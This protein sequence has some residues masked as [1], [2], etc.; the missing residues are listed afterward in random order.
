MSLLSVFEGDF[1]KVT[2][3]ILVGTSDVPVDDTE[4]TNK[5][6]VDDE[7]NSIEHWLRDVGTATVFL[8]IPG[9][10]VAGSL[11]PGGALEIESTLNVVKGDITLT[12]PQ[13]NISNDLKVDSILEKTP[14]NG[15][16]IDSLKI[17]DNTLSSTLNLELQTQTNGVINFSDTGSTFAVL[18]AVGLSFQVPSVLG[19]TDPNGT[20]SLFSTSDVTKGAITMTASSV[21]IS[22]DLKVNSILEKTN[23]NGINI[24][25]SLIK[26][27]QL[28]P[29]S[30]TISNFIDVL[31][32]SLRLSSVADTFQIG[33]G[34][35]MQNTLAFSQLDSVID[36]RLKTKSASGIISFRDSSNSNRFFFNGATD[37]ILSPAINKALPAGSFSNLSILDSNGTIGIGPALPT[38][39]K[40][41]SL[42]DSNST[43]TSPALKLNINFTAT[44][45][46]YLVMWYCEVNV[47]NAANEIIVNIVEDSGSTIGFT[48]VNSDSANGGG[49]GS[50]SGHAISTFATGS[51]DYDMFFNS[52]QG[53]QSVNIRRAR[54]A[55]IKIA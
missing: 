55:V 40:A 36:L 9:D 12:A 13:V 31:S 47:F 54:F 32:G 16:A 4:L 26:D 35:S 49:F 19:S 41:E 22:N 6:Y 1:S 46:D 7:V 18:D 5:K 53:A 14:A 28:L 51:R 44:A 11:A 48:N 43:S 38:V 27:K 8:R 37:T 15:I 50:I 42:G 39:F 29:D 21:D 30:T 33:L 24:D 25:G 45:G 3:K 23:N 20:L 34:L 17:K 10:K 2:K 52:G